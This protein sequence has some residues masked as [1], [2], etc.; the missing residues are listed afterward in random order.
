MDL[1]QEIISAET[2]FQQKLEE[3]FLFVFPS[4]IIESHDLSHHRRVWSYARDLL[5][6]GVTEKNSLTDRLA[7]KM[8]IAAYMHDTGMSVDPGPRH[9]IHSRRFCGEF[10]RKNDLDPGKFTDLLDAVEKHDDKEY[11]SSHENDPLLRL[12]AV[13]DDLDALGHTGI[14]RYLEIYLMRGIGFRE[15]GVMIGENVRTRFRNIEKIYGNNHDLMRKH[16]PRF[17]IIAEFFNR[18]NEQA[19]NYAFGKGSPHGW[20]GVAE[21][22][23]RSVEKGISLLDLINDVT[24]KTNDIIIKQ[25]FSNL[26]RELN[27]K[28]GASASPYAT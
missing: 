11:R 16:K 25:Y 5:H 1:S 6:N 8:I 9:G 22:I 3:F 13:A 4:V 12:L 27:S 15:T 7:D 19:L 2:R 14:Y 18:Y 26:R 17:E 10:L 24:I 28:F 20:C 23:A 21:L